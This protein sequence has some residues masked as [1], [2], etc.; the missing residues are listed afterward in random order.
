LSH[1]F[2][3]FILITV[4]SILPAGV[5][6]LL[7]IWYERNINLHLYNKCSWFF[8][9]IQFFGF[10]ALLSVAPEKMDRTGI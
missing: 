10:K 6:A 5:Q 9:N 1:P 2:S 3:E 8:V 4:H 7:R